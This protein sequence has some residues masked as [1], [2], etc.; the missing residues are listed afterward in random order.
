MN[1][2]EKKEYYAQL[3]HAV[4]TGVA[5]CIT[6]PNPNLARECEPKHL[7]TGLNV[8]MCEHSALVR[9]L[10]KKGVITEEEYYDEVIVVLKA[11]VASYEKRL[12]PYGNFKLA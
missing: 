9:L 7:R 5:F 10:M 2:A 8:V 4:Q 3:A 12:A 6:G 1:L 11:E